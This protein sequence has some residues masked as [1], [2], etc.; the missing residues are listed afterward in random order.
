MVPVAVSLLL[1][2]SLL[3]LVVG[4]AVGVSVANMNPHY[5]TQTAFKTETQIKTETQTSVS[6]SMVTIVTTSTDLGNYYNQQ[7]YNSQYPYNTQYPYNGQYPY[8]SQNP[9]YPNG[10]SAQ[11]TLNGIIDPHQTG[12]G[13]IYLQTAGNQYYLL[14]NLPT[15]YKTGFVTVTGTL[16]NGNLWNV[17]NRCSNSGQSIQVISIY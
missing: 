2:G 1:V 5:V 6:M 16:N 8:N 15:K 4:Y 11:V 17:F 12:A 13:C 10:N 7:P 9:Q 3:F 14:Q